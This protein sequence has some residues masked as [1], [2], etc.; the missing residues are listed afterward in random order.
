MSLVIPNS[1][2]AGT[3][4]RAAEVNAN[5]QAIVGKFSEGSGGIVDADCATGMDLNSAAKLSGTAGKRV[6]VAKMEDDAVDGRVLKD[7]NNAGSPNAAVNLVN[8]IKDGLI[9]KGK[10]STVAGT[11]IA[12]AQLDMLIEE[13]AFSV[14]TGAGTMVSFAVAVSRITVGANHQGQVRIAIQPVGTV[15]LLLPVTVVPTTAIPFAT[16]SLKALY[17]ADVAYVNPNITGKVV[18]VSMPNS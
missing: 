10:L 18:F 9:P 11:Q 8:H 3:K 6:T 16:R 5:F 1:F 7:D 4:A 14:N 15:T 2:V 17:V 12:I 13:V